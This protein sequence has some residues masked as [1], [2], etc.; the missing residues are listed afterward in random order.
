MNKIVLDSRVW[1]DCLLSSH[2]K[3]TKEIKQY[4]KKIK[5]EQICQQFEYLNDL[6]LNPPNWFRRNLEGHPVVKDKPSYFTA[7]KVLDGEMRKTYK[8]WGQDI[9]F[10]ESRL[11]WFDRNADESLI[12]LFNI[13]K[14]YI[15][16]QLEIVDQSAST[17]LYLKMSDI[18][19]TIIRQACQEGIISK[20]EVNKHETR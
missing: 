6:Y 14:Q 18:G 3:L 13:S 4:K 10:L 15:K 9:T 1:K 17:I 16:A 12:R 19:M 20:I 2:I 5:R 7:V 11:Y 8:S